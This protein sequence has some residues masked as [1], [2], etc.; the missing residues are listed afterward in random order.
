MITEKI[1]GRMSFDHVLLAARFPLLNFDEWD[2][3]IRCVHVVGAVLVPER[4]QSLGAGQRQ[5]IQ[6]K[7][8]SL[9]PDHKTSKLPV[10]KDIKVTNTE[11]EIERNREKSKEI[12]RNQSNQEIKREIEKYIYRERASD[13]HLPETAEAHNTI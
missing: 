8:I 5:V 9:V 1:T 7:F 10:V 12:K 2:V 4:S 13:C 6:F 11:R 3:E